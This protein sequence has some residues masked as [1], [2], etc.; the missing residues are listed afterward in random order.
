MWYLTVHHWTGEQQTSIAAALA[1]KTLETHLSWMR[2]QQRAGTV[3]IAGPAK[4]FELGII[5]FGHLSEDTVHE[6]CRTEPLVAAG[7]RDY[8]LI[9]WDVHHLLGIGEFELKPPPSMSDPD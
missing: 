5:V 6:L 2:E 1:D 9:P 8:E 4:G 7:H 3:L